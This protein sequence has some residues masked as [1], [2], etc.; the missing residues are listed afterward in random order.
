MSWLTQRL[1]IQ[2]E[3]ENRVLRHRFVQRQ[4]KHGLAPCIEQ[5]ELFDMEGPI[6]HGISVAGVDNNGNRIRAQVTR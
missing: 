5:V 3:R 4:P 6:E 2:I 1:G